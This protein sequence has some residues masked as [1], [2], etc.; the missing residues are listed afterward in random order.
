MWTFEFRKDWKVFLELEQF[1]KTKK[2]GHKRYGIFK[3]K[4]IVRHQP[5]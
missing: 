5:A 1:R 3:N 4:G 2:C